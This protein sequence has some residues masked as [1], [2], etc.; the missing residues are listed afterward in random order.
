[1]TDAQS[2]RRPVYRTLRGFITQAGAAAPTTTILQNDFAELDG[3]D[4]TFTRSGA[5]SYLINSPLGLFPAN[6]TF[7]NVY[8][9]FGASQAGIGRTIAGFM[10]LAYRISNTQIEIDTAYSQLR[11]PSDAPPG[12]L[13][14][15]N[16]YSDGL[17][18]VSPFEVLVYE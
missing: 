18:N 16:V 11:K 2:M 15:E 13:D 6:K 5:G 10:A 7:V 12:N 3:E 8:Q 9:P 4:I 14:L 17:L 1:M